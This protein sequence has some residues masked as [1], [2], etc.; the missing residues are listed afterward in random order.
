MSSPSAHEFFVLG[1]HDHRLP[2]FIAG[3]LSGLVASGGSLKG[4]L[5]GA[6]SA[7]MFEWAGGVGASAAGEYSAAHFGAHAL[8]GC[9]SSA[10]GGGDCGQGALSAVAGKAGTWASNGNMA[11]TVVAGGVTSALGGGKFANGAMT[12]A[13]GYMFNMCQFNPQ[14]CIQFLSNIAQ[15][16]ALPLQNLWV[17]FGPQTTALAVEL[18]GV[19]GTLPSPSA[20]LMPAGKAIGWVEGGAKGVQTVFK[21]EFDDV[22]GKLLRQS[23]QVEKG[24]FPGSWY[25]LENGGEFGV[26]MS[27]T[28]QTI[29]IKNIPGVS[30]FDKIHYVPDLEIPR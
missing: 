24:N 27:A 11:I 9:A 10:I 20:I 17:R 23:Q 4:A 2:L 6:V 16:I 21:S 8:A 1:L 26:R 14:V 5:Q 13:Y 12:S 19:N 30:G 3:G 18:G 28:G 15:R 29:Q 22:L 25:K 7:G